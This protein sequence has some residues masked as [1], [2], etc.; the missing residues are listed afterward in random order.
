MCI[1]EAPRNYVYIYMCI[2]LYIDCTHARVIFFFCMYNIYI[3][4]ICKQ[5]KKKHAHQVKRRIQDGR[6]GLGKGL[7]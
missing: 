5:K 2:Y 6:W 7:G 4:R 3:S 1:S